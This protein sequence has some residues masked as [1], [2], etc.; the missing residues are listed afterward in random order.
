MADIHRVDEILHWF[1]LGPCDT[2][3]FVSPYII[4][5]EQVAIVETGPACGHGRLVEVLDELGLELSQVDWIL[6]THIHLD[7]G[8]GA[9]HLASVCPNAQVLLHPIGLPHLLDPERLWSGSLKVL[10]EVARAYGK[11]MPLGRDRVME[12][13]DGQIIELGRTELNVHFTPGHASHHL[14]YFEPDR[15]WLFSGDAAGLSYSKLDAAIPV[16]PP[17]YRHDRQLTSLARLM[18]LDPDLLCY[19]HFGPQEMAA[20]RLKQVEGEYLTWI[21]HAIRAVELRL[22]VEDAFGQFL[23]SHRLAKAVQKINEVR[24]PQKETILHS[25]EGMMRYSEWKC[26]TER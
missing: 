16:T 5:D 23:A 8:G 15:G 26:K 24:F 11:P 2:P 4:L 14:S 18:D 1:D 22:E 19:T 20:Q 25:I 13:F 6:P 12:A 17:P 9:G 21:T 7:H 3:E 10:G